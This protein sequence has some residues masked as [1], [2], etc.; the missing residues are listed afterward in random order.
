MDIQFQKPRL[1]ALLDHFSAIED[2]RQPWK[3]MYPFARSPVSDRLRHHCGL[4]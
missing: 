2:T 1:A 3:V 4:R